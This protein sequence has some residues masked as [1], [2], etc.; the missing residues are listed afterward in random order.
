MEDPRS[1]LIIKPSSLG[2]VVHALPVVACVKH[3]WPDARITWVVNPEWAPLLEGNPHLHEVIEFPRKQFRGVFGWLRFIRWA[4]S[5]HRRVRPDLVLDL[6]GLL[7]S[8]L[9]GWFAGGTMWGMTDSREGSRLLHDAV[10]K[11]GTRREPVHAVRRMLILAETLKCDTSGPLEWPLPAG[12]APAVP[13]PPH[14]VVLHPFSR[15]AGKSLSLAEVSNFCR[16]LAP[17]PVVIVGGPGSAPKEE[18]AVD[19]LGRT[20][21]PELCWVIRR[22]DFVVSV[23]SG[24]SHI[25]A[26]LTDRL[27]AIHTW[28]DPRQVGP[29]RPNAWVWKDGR[30]GRMSEFPQGEPIERDRLGPWVKAQIG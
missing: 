30:L 16:A 4:R 2:D 22:A 29:Y 27:L 10:A 17:L 21:L 9:I 13:L 12:S 18:N 19:L 15:G 24:P 5:L 25:A 28:S 26:A 1:I 20:T 7:R 11:V 6:Q 23:D 8:A 3:R 14:F